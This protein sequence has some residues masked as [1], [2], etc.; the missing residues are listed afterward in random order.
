MDNISCF[1]NDDICVF[2][3]EMQINMDRA[4]EFVRSDNSGAISSFVGCVRADNV[5]GKMVESLLYTAYIPMALRGL[6]KIATDLKITDKGIKR[7]YIQHRTGMVHVGEASVMI[8]VSRERTEQV[9]DN[10]KCILDKV[11]RTVPIWKKNIFK[12][13]I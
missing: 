8:V 5:D 4:F 12:P 2:I 13:L 10:V 3:S 9:F 7:I 11:K 1:K 6:M